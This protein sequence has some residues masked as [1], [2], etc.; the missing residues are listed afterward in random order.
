MKILCGPGDNSGCGFYRIINPY[1]HLTGH[2]VH[3]TTAAAP[4][5]WKQYDLAVI[6]RASS[7]DMMLL[8]DY[9]NKAGVPIVMDIDDNIHCMAPSNPA[10]VVYSNGKEATRQFEEAM[11]KVALVTTST[12]DL[13]QEYAKFRPD[14]VVLGNHIA[15]EQFDAMAPKEISGRPKVDGQIRIGY[16]AGCAHMG[17]VAMIRRPLEKIARKYPQVKLVFFGC[18]P[19][20]QKVP[21]DLIG[22]IEFNPGIEPNEKEGELP[23][24]FMERYYKH[25]ESLQL[26]IG[27]APLESTTFNR[28]RSFVKALE[29]GM[30]GIPVVASNFGPYREYRK[31]GGTILTAGDG[32]EWLFH[33]ESLVTGRELIREAIAIQNLAFVREHGT[34]KSTIGQWERMLENFRP[35][36]HPAVETETPLV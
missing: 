24:Q 19:P 21:E 16:A 33:L 6:Q 11:S 30:L 26:D 25:V 1:S 3:F 34:T 13:A 28:C 7:D 23:P 35:A 9:L 8:I 27:I 36:D 17:D 4:E 12:A 29:Y 32:R 10:F 2:Q 22:Q 14:M 31:L 15:Q 20:W 5:L 18:L